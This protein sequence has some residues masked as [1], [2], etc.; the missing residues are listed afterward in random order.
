MMNS[1]VATICILSLALSVFGQRPVGVHFDV[2]PAALPGGAEGN[3]AQFIALFQKLKAVT[4]GNTRLS[5]DL[6]M[7]MG[8]KPL[9]AWYYQNR[10][11]SYH[12][13]DIVDTVTLMAYRDRAAAP[14]GITDHAAGYLNYARQI[15][16]NVVVGVE[17]NCNLGNIVSFCEEGQTYM[18]QQLNSALTTLK[19]YG[20]NFAGL[21]IHDYD[22]YNALSGVSST[23]RLPSSAPCRALWVWSHSVVNDP[24]AR[25]KFI[26]FC[27]RM[28]I[29]T[30]Y[31]ESQGLVDSSA[32][33]PVL[34][35]FIND[36]WAKGI[37]VELLFGNHEWTYTANHPAAVNLAKAAV[38]FIN[39]FPASGGTP[40]I[41]STT[42]A[43]VVPSTTGAP[44]NGGGT[45][46]ARKVTRRIRISDGNDDVEQ[47]PSKGNKMYCTSSDLEFVKDG[48][49]DQI[50]GLRFKNVDVSPQDTIVGAYLEMKSKKSATTKTNLVIHGE[51]TANSQG[52]CDNSNLLSDKTKTSSSVSWN[53][54]PSW[55]VGQIVQSP[56]VT[57]VVKEIV[58][59]NGWSAGNAMTL[60]VSGSG[61]RSAYSYNGGAAPYLVIELQTLSCG[62]GLPTSDET[63]DWW[64]DTTN[65]VE[66]DDDE[67]NA[68]SRTSAFLGLMTVCAVVAARLF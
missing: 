7:G 49:V 66:P 46:A 19:S 58:G 30:V 20:S 54:V 48:T 59:M 40:V 26:D 43:P 4:N 9:G 12:I 31:Q 25:A 50:L 36:L 65:T 29:C 37:Q 5:A 8:L 52:L 38:N 28:R 33:Q 62:A 10:P 45:C 21:A 57:A 22:G 47:Q 16:K 17:T 63:T 15:G 51:K 24:A 56:D 27:V 18:E 1:C 64:A 35:S 3:A 14:N 42:A 68:S 61:M 60:I 2:E 32:K 55:S 11:I 44:N 6:P 67:F 23:F 53:N 41:P 34:R 13:A 39:T